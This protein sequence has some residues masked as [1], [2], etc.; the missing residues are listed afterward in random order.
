MKPVGYRQQLVEPIPTDPRHPNYYEPTDRTIVRHRDLPYRD[1]DSGFGFRNPGGV[2]RFGE[3]MPPGDEFQNPGR[4]RVA[5]TFSGTN[6][7]V[8][9]DQQIQMAAVGNAQNQT[10]YNHMAAYAR[11]MGFY[12]FGYNGG[13][14][15]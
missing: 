8:S 2:G 15:Y 5:A 6:G 13:M 12:G 4:A 14:M 3:F 11:P 1:S 7:V 10:M 9:R